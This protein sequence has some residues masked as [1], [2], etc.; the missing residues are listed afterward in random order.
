MARRLLAASLLGCALLLASSA[1]DAA[2][3]RKKAT[4]RSATRGKKR[5]TAPRPKASR[6]TKASLTST[7]SSRRLRASANGLE[8]AA[9]ENALVDL[10]A[11]WKPSASGDPRPF[12]RMEVVIADTSA[13]ARGNRNTGADPATVSIA[14]RGLT[15]RHNQFTGGTGLSA[16]RIV[17]G[18]GARRISSKVDRDDT[19][20]EIAGKLADRVNRLR[21]E[22]G[23]PYYSA[24]ARAT[25]GK[26][27]LTIW[28]GGAFE[29]Q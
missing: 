18:F 3:A 15:T 6:G 24:S 21:R 20:L 17:Y 28:P 8:V 12:G 16:N 5:S 10:A 19:A 9:S 22:D 26:V 13:K 14:L 29:S 7:R 11:S 27:V 4:P 1:T 25:G 2:T 23:V